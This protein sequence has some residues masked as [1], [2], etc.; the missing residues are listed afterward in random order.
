MNLFSKNKKQSNTERTDENQ[1]W[2]KTFKRNIINKTGSNQQGFDFKENI[3]IQALKPSLGI[4]QG[5]S[6][7]AQ[8]INHYQ[9]EVLNKCANE[10]TATELM[11]ILKRTNKTKFKQ[12]ILEPLIACDFFE[13]TIPDKPTSP[14]Q[15][16][17]LTGRFVKKS[18][19]NN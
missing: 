18:S 5:L 2:N 10:N 11:K 4:K 8:D 1:E 14:K 12:T 15:K 16:Y 13:L 19:I 6:Y 17:R 3:Y 7:K 9:I